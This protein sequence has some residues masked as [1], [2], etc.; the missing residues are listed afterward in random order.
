MFVATK[1]TQYICCVYL[2]SLR[3]IMYNDV[4]ISDF[5]PVISKYST[6]GHIYSISTALSGLDCID[7]IDGSEPRR[8]NKC[9]TYL[10]IQNSVD[11][12]CCTSRDDQILGYILRIDVWA[13]GHD[14]GDHT[15]R[16]KLERGTSVPIHRVHLGLRAFFGKPHSVLRAG[17]H[18]ANR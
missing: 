11:C 17:L 10:T 6:K 12:P 14:I 4:L 8:W 9:F 15:L 5:E 3:T 1:S 16:Y 2:M 7:E 18:N 13:H